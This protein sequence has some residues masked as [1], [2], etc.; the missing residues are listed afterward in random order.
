MSRQCM[1]STIDNPFNPFDNFDEW[2]AYDV[3]FGY[4]CCELVGQFA[5]ISSDL[6]QNANHREI[7]SA[8]DAVI[9]EDPLNIYTKIVKES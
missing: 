2:F 4:H 7:E 6:S 5:Q 3:F 8:I 9:R 1:L